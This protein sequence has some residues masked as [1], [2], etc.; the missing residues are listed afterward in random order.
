M[1]F[2]SAYIYGANFIAKFRWENGFLRGVSWN[3]E[4]VKV[5]WSLKLGVKPVTQNQN[6]RHPT[7]SPSNM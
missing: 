1:V 2:D 6:I 3:P 5:P 7:H 4:T